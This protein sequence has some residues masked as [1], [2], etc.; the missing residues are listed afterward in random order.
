V[1]LLLDTC[2]FL[3][4]AAG[5]TQLSRRA[6]QLFTD[7]ANEVF[8]SAVSAWEIAAKNSLGRL[9]LPG[10]PADY[11]ASLRERLG[12]APLPIKEEEALYL[13]RIPRLHRDPFDRMLVCQAII[14]GLAL[15]TPDPLIA[16]Y[17]VRT[18]W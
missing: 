17:P 7:P 5:S 8:L 18:I 11:I 16:Q 13:P 10:P 6:A 9:T 14:N 1:K 12:I 15:L 4:I 3:W 2:T